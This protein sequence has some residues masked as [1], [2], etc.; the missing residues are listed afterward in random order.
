MYTHISLISLYTYRSVY[1]NNTLFRKP[2]LLGPPLSLPDYSVSIT[3]I[4]ITIIIITII[5]T[6]ILRLHLQLLFLLLFRKPPLLGPPLS[7]ATNSS[8]YVFSPEFS[9]IVV[10]RI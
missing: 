3:S 7:C 5:I 1:E 10:P 4:S 8:L 6:V 2:P 9:Q